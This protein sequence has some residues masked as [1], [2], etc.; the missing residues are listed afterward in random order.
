[1]EL[2][3]IPSGFLELDDMTAGFQPGELIIIAARPS[4]GKT[5]FSLNIAMNAALR[6]RKTV[7]YFSVEMGKEQVMMRMLSGEAKIP[8]GQLRSGNIDEF[9]WPKLINT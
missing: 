4:M 3:G 2:T 6:E 8:A 9:A 5:A 1:M 7:A